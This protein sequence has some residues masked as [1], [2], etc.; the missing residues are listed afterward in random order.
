MQ[1]SN[2]GKLK[3]GNTGK[4]RHCCV[5]CDVSGRLPTVVVPLAQAEWSLNV[6]KKANP[7]AVTVPDSTLNGGHRL[8]QDPVLTGGATGSANDDANVHTYG[9]P[10]T[11]P[12]HT[13][14]SPNP[15]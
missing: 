4:L 14:A 9:L 13:A 8:T 3:G 10:P 1:R 2:T 7:Q 12:K 5:V 11:D 15:R 6:S